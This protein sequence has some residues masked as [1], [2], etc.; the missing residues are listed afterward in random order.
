[1]CGRIW[2]QSPDNIHY[3]STRSS[4]PNPVERWFAEITNKRVRRESWES[5]PQLTMAIKDY[6]KTWNKSGGTLCG[7]KHPMKYL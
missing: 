1:M 5:I 4:W 7:Q 2:I 6:I 3:I